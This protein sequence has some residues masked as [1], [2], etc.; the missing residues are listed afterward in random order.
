[1][2]A[3]HRARCGSL[4]LAVA[5]AGCATHPRPRPETAAPTA[6]GSPAQLLARIQGDAARSDAATGAA[7]ESL[8]EDAARL[9]AACLGQASDSAV[10]QYG[11]AVALG[12]NARAHP[13]RASALLT[14]M[15]AAL[16]KAEALDPTLDAAGPARVRALVL[17]R[18]PGWPLGP[19]DAEAAVTAARDAVARRP[20]Y[21]PNQLALAEALTKAGETDEARERYRQAAAAAAAAPPGAERDQWLHEAERGLK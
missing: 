10:C 3:E 11:N 21:A 15:L 18:A 12:L 13:G 14:Q 8:A 9:A 16:T 20:D 7:R 6:E 1:M 5:L 19:G 17:A 2:S 4:L